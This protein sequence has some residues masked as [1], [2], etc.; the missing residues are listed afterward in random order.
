[1]YNQDY[2][3]KM[4]ISICHNIFLDQMKSIDVC[5]SP[6]LIHL[7]ELEGKITVVVDILRF[8]SCIVTGIANGVKEIIPFASLED[9]RMMR[10]QG[11]FI[12]GE[13]GG[14]KLEDFDIGNSPFN[15]MEEHLKGERIAVTT[16]N[17][18]LAIDR[19]KES[20]EIIIGSFLNISAIADYLRNKPNDVLLV[21]A[22]WK[23]RINLEDTLFAGALAVMLED[24]YE[25]ADDAV[26]VARKIYSENSGQMMDLIRNSSH[27]MRLK[28]FNVKNDIDFCLT[29]DQ[30]NVVPVLREGKIVEYSSSV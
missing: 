27:A 11:Y 8:T 13:R 26:I 4:R 19:S 15:Y 16:T 9:C 12:A 25:S 29:H 10:S 1:M 14:Q 18:T 28:K 21:C 22:G 23:G 17:G 30:Y 3:E 7:Y 2:D 6:D 24:D 20:D 5:L